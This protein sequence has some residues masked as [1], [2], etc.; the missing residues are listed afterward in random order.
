MVKSMNHK[1]GDGDG[2]KGKGKGKGLGNSQLSMLK[3]QRSTDDNGFDYYIPEKGKLLRIRTSI[4]RMGNGKQFKQNN[5]TFSPVEE[6]KIHISE[7]SNWSIQ[8]DLIPT[9]LVGTHTQ[10][11]EWFGRI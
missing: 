3:R 11:D 4:T 10:G 1:N 6:E 9:P 2:G 5:V 8:S 7:N